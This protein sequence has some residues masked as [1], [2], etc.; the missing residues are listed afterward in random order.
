LSSAYLSTL[1][2]CNSQQVLEILNTD[3]NPQQILDIMNSKE[4]YVAQR[5]HLTLPVV[6]AN[7]DT[8]V[9][10]PTICQILIRE[11]AI[12]IRNKYPNSQGV[13]QYKQQAFPQQVWLGELNGPNG[14]YAMFL[15]M[16]STAATGYM[17]PNIQ[18]T[19]SSG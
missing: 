12:D 13:G 18:N 14:L 8:T 5:C 3:L 10:L 11:T 15:R 16:P 6:L 7:I 4:G 2:G 19:W 17:T 9:I 1:F